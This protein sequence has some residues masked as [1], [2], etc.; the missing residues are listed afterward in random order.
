ML[1]NRR[2]IRVKYKI[3][4]IT[5]FIPTNQFIYHS[6]LLFH[7]HQNIKFVMILLVKFVVF[8]RG[9]LNRFIFQPGQDSMLMFRIGSFTF[10]PGM[11]T[12]IS[13]K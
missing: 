13:S 9:F 4:K 8:G 5:I 10:V 1:L 6:A 7:I 3:E 2:K 11:R 12:R